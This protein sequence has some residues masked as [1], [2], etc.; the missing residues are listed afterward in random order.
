MDQGL[1]ESKPTSSRKLTKKTQQSHD[2]DA[3]RKENILRRNPKH[4]L[5]RWLT[6]KG[7]ALDVLLNSLVACPS[8]S[9]KYSSRSACSRSWPVDRHVSILV[10]YKP[11][12]AGMIVPRVVEN[13]QRPWRP[14][15]PHQPEGNTL[16]WNQRFPA[17]PSTD[18]SNLTHRS[19]NPPT[20]FM[21]QPLEAEEAQSLLPVNE[22]SLNHQSPTHARIPSI[23]SKGASV[24]TWLLHRPPLFAVLEL[25]QTCFNPVPQ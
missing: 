2:S 23:S 6:Y 12:T 7:A 24:L 11:G 14:G 18:R 16:S 19:L 13:V 8:E 9:S 5:A 1:S 3:T 15:T 21:G 17:G 20:T 10:I 25:P 4:V 22:A